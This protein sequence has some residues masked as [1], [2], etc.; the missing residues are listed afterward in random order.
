MINMDILYCEKVYAK[1]NNK[2]LFL[3][4]AVRSLIYIHKHTTKTK[5]NSTPRHLTRSRLNYRIHTLHLR[6]YFVFNRF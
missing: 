3:N 4:V 5:E 6:A 2:N 1:Y